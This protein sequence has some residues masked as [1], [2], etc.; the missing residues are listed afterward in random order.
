MI[1]IETPHH[2]TYSDT[3]E[4]PYKAC[5]GKC[6]KAWWK[7]DFESRG[8]KYCPQC[9]GKLRPATEGKHF[10]VI[11]RRNGSVKPSDFDGLQT[12]DGKPIVNVEMLERANLQHLSLVKPEFADKARAEWC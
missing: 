2:T 4:L 8:S 5:T 10:S 12:E 6:R 7:F 3:T 11:E 9:R 1:A